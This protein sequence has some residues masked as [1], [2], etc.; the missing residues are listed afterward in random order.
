V[1][2]STAST[3]TLKRRSNEMELVRD[4]VSKGAPAKQM[5]YEIRTLGKKDREAI[6]HQALGTAQSIAIPA[7]Q[8]LAMKADLSITWNKLRDMRR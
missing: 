6:L 2:S 3:R 7:D 8:V 5:E 1:E 4:L